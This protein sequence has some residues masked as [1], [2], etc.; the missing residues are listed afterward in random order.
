MSR[1]RVRAF[2]GTLIL[3]WG[4]TATEVPADI[5]ADAQIIPLPGKVESQPG[6]FML[7][8]STRIV[9]SGDED[10]RWIANWLADMLRRT[11][12]IDL[13]VGDGSIAPVSNSIVFESGGLRGQA[14]PEA[15]RLAV[16]P[17]N[18]VVAANDTAGL[19][20]GA[21]SLWQLATA[22]ARRDAAIPMPAMTIDDAP[23]FAWRGLML[24]AARHYVS[25]QFVRQMIDWMAL[26]K[27]NVLH[28]H[29]TDDQG[30]RLE[31][32]AYP[33]L[34]E[35]GAWRVPAG[36]AAQEDVDPQTGETRRYGAFYTKGDVREIVAYARRR[37]VTIVP[38]IEMPGHA[39]AAIAAYPEFG[40]D[41]E[42]PDVS[43]DWGI[44]SY[45]F[46]VE[47]TT[48]GA[49]E[50]ILAEVLE[51]FPGRYIHVGGD[52]AVKERWIGSDRVQQR[53]RE[54]GVGSEAELQS[55]FI[56]RIEKFLRANG[57]RL[58]GWDE[59][60]EGGIAPEATVMSWRGIDGA[61]D[62][63]T[64]G[65]DTV[66][67]PW[68][69]LYFDHRQSVL[70][71]EP[72]GRGFVVSLEDVYRFEPLPA[73][74]AD[75]GEQHVLGL[76]ANLWS[77]HIRTEDRLAYMAF[78]RA[79]ALAE[80]AWSQPHRLD[81]NDF[82]L[83]LATQFDRYRSLDMPFATSAFDV[84][85][86]AKIAGRDGINIELSNQSGLGAI[87]YSVDGSKVTLKS[88]QY[89]GAL[90][91]PAD[92]EIAAATFVQDRQMSRE[93]RANV[94][95]TARRR[96]SHDLS[97]CSER[98]VLS[99]EDDAPVEGRRSVFLIDI[100]NPCWTWEE[101]DLSRISGIKVAVGQVP[102]N[103]QLGADRDKIELPQPDSAA[104]ELEVREDGCEGPVMA[105]LPL[106][107]AAQSNDVT[108]LSNKL[109][110]HSDKTTD[111]CFRFTADELDPMWAIDWIELVPAMKP[112]AARAQ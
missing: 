15:Y 62:A 52:E 77:E 45:L 33:R 105:V 34:T 102:F 68:P 47:E 20:Y 18:V 4:C 75:A 107:E 43:T 109:S 67:S 27:L 46:N 23:R 50:D 5:G 103:F 53:M 41:D 71:G 60:L 8:P 92:V 80:I 40:V 42:R 56:K 37:H 38:E 3:L 44:H 93:T 82:V 58:I 70:A 69:T 24:D 87:R 99:L 106:D 35:V 112:S 86:T 39:Q 10:V 66:L 51:L 90:E 1:S 30:W 91:L 54:L 36:R 79:A 57:R 74:L 84:Q 28:W 13:E 21:V 19:F 96:F 97:L 73:A 94:G 104:G 64:L 55:Y 59:I 14:G 9:A 49:L 95:R 72:P 101:A 88:A 6:V 31:I 29:L 12:Q 11:A 61:V 98:L 25:P 7:Q 2:A 76:Q 16:S 100:M 26:H 111:L 65:H 63:A 83:R 48:F 89:S 108:V 85:L 81:W 32:E 78:P 17:E 22:T 110:A